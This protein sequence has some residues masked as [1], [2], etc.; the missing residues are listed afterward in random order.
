MPH[1]VCEFG[2]KG[3]V[4]CSVSACVC[5]HLSSS[6]NK[7]TPT[8]VRRGARDDLL[9]Q[10]LEL[11]RDDLCDAAPCRVLSSTVCDNAT[12]LKG[13][14]R[15]CR[16]IM[17]LWMF[18]V[19]GPSINSSSRCLFFA[20]FCRYYHTFG[21]HYSYTLHVIRGLKDIVKGRLII[22]TFWIASQSLI[23]ILRRGGV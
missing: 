9:N 2:S 4:C 23:A 19:T 14:L 11:L 16:T 5:P 3:R 22:R 8:R 6:Q 18:S 1:C 12:A 13:V 10:V 20:E 21:L 7:K 15:Y 17:S